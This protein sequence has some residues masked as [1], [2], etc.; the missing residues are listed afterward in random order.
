M[1]PGPFVFVG[2]TT[3][4]V[5]RG[6]TARPDHRLPEAR[7]PARPRGREHPHHAR[8][9]GRVRAA[10]DALFDRQ[11]LVGPAA[12][13]AE[14][15]LPRA[16]SVSAAPRR[17]HLQVPRDDRVPRRD[18]QGR[19]RAADRPHQPGG[20]RRRH[21][22]VQGRHAALLRAAQ[23]EVAARRAR[24]PATSTPPS[25]APAATRSGRAPRS[26]SS[27]SATRTASGIRSAS[28]PSCGSC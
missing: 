17:H 27:R 16:D 26:A 20:D 14:G 24:R 8:G 15:V 2:P 3:T 28:G 25:A 13:G 5:H 1:N 7:P 4:D 23:D 11:G 19:R 21:A 22:A 10:G 6:R 18:G 12:A 9:G